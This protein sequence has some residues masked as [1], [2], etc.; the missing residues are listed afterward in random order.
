[1]TLACKS[2]LL[3][4][5]VSHLIFP[6]EVAGIEREGV[7]ADTPDGRIADVG[8]SP[9]GDALQ[10]ALSMLRSAQR[11]V[12][13]VGHGAR[14]EMAAITELAER[15]NSPVL[16]TFKGKGLISD[17]HPLGCGV[18]GRSGTPVASWFMNESDLL[19]VLGASFSNHTG[20][21]P[22]EADDPGG[23]RPDDAGEVP[24]GGLPGLRGPGADRAA[25]DGGGRERRAG[26]PAGGGRRAVGRCGVRRSGRA[27]QTTAGKG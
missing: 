2:A 18:L 8:V 17:A 21:T 10:R 15:L 1:M 27:W 25:A 3:N 5:G 24:Q 12:I 16:T 4:Q 9:P 6:D 22:E 20:I 23:P 19:L 11:P 13:V 7:E 14:Y 26:R